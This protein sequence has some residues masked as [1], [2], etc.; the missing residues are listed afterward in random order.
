MHLMVDQAQPVS[1]Y[2]KQLAGCMGGSFNE[3]AVSEMNGTVTN[4]VVTSTKRGLLT[5]SIF[6]KAFPNSIGVLVEKGIINIGFGIEGRAKHTVNMNEP[7]CRAL[8]KP[9]NGH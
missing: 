4:E 6:S 1:Q 8:K 5:H 9:T 2:A 3:E 7:K